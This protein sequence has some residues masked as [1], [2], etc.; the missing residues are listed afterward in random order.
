MKNIPYH[1]ALAHTPPIEGIKEIDYFK[2]NNSFAMYHDLT[3]KKL[4]FEFYLC[5]LIYSDPAWYQGLKTFNERAG[6]SSTIETYYKAISDAVIKLNRATILNLGSRELK[7]MPKPDLVFKTYL[8]HAT[9]ELVYT[10]VYNFLPELDLSG[11][12]NYQIL[13]L[14]SNSFDRIGDFNCGYGNSG[15]I[16]VENGKSFVM[17]DYNK[18]CIGYIASEYQNWTK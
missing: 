18:K 13:K 10:A 7:R 8:S 14:L 11:M 15:K 4:P 16:F 3:I 17:S 1:S 6:G 2:I 9:K 12:T 5:D